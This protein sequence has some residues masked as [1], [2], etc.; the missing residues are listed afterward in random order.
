MTTPELDEMPAPLVHRVDKITGEIDQEWVP[1]DEI[2]E[3]G[4]RRGGRFNVTLVR[5]TETVKEEHT[6]VTL[7]WKMDADDSG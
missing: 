3:L 5:I 1:R 4:L 6:E 2:P 7:L